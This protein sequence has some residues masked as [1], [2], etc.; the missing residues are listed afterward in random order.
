MDKKVVVRLLKDSRLETILE[1]GPIPPN[2]FIKAHF[3][4]L[5]LVM[6]DKILVLQFLYY[7]FVL[8]LFISIFVL[9]F[10]IAIFHC[11]LV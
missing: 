11:N 8:Q 9:K 1:K 5:M 10:C 2:T 4:G 7:N 3:D 6:P